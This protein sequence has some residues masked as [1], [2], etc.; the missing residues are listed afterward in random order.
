MK[1]D[2]W[3][4]S[5][6]MFILCIAET[7]QGG[8]ILCWSLSGHQ[9]IDGANLCE[10]PRFF[11]DSAD[12]LLIATSLFPKSLFCVTFVVVSE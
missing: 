11:A 2:T 3:V 7:E 9:W 10:R 6:L 4:K 8:F 1:E 5:L 12:M